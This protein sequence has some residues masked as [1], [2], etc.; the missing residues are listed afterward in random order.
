MFF[1]TYKVEE[2]VNFLNS[3]YIGRDNYIILVTDNKIVCKF[4]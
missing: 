3:C 1:E 4:I 2:I